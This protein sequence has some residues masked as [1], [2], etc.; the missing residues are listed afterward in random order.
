MT[1][2]EMV[3]LAD[4]V[5]E[6]VSEDSHMTVLLLHSLE[7]NATGSARLVDP[8]TAEDPDIPCRCFEFEDE[9]YCWKK[10]YLGLISEEKNPEQ[11]SHCKIRIP[12]GAGTAERFGKM[13]GAIEE[14]HQEWEKEDTGLTGWWSKVGQ[15]LEEKGVTL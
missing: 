11:M 6:K 1:E 5:A 14:A 2:E 9:I 15:K 8:Q 12:A 13:K 10:G 4:M 7:H 3:R